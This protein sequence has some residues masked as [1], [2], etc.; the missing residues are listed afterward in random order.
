[1]KPSIIFVFYGFIILALL[2]PLPKGLIITENKE[3]HNEITAMNNCDKIQD[4]R[5]IT[6][7]TF[8]EN[9]EYNNIRFFENRDTFKCLGNH[10]LIECL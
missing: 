6:I 10:F 9:Y 5:I 3:L 2:F 8:D 1:M 7:S 4:I